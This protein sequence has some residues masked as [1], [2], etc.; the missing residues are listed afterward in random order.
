MMNEAR[1]LATKRMVAEAK[2]IKAYMHFY[3]L[4]YY[5]PICPLRENTPVNESTQ[6]VRVY[7]EKVDDCFAYILELL[8]E[9]IEG[10]PLPLVIENQIERNWGV[11]HVRPLI[12]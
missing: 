4:S 3:L 10:D 5:G 9:V 11:L 8:D 7:R 12:C 6:G 1:A 2:L